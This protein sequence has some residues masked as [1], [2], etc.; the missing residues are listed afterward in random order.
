MIDTTSL[1]DSWLAAFNESYTAAA[2][3]NADRNEILD[4]LV[5]DLTSSLET[6]IKSATVTVVAAPGA[7]AVQGTP[8]AQANVAPVVITGN[9]TNTGGIS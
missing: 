6:W 9:A 4:K 8:S 7:I 2:D 1:K 3:S 5:S